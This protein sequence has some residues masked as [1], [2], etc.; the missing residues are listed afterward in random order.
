MSVWETT[1][2]Q[3]ST[4]SQKPCP[5]D[6]LRR[7]WRRTRIKSCLKWGHMKFASIHS[8]R[9]RMRR[10][11]LSPSTG[12]T[13]FTHQTFLADSS[14]FESFCESPNEAPKCTTA[15]MRCNFERS[16]LWTRYKRFSVCAHCNDID[17]IHC[18][19]DVNAGRSS[20]PPPVKVKNSKY[21]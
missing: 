17:L 15:E 6:L 12:R 9:R 4:T 7:E 20:F 5:R 2:R 8:E 18:C 1:A 14:S 16:R 21:Y 11:N 10:S 3:I 13:E 19:S